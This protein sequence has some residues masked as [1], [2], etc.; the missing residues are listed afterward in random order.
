MTRPVASTPST[1]DDVAD[2]AK[3]IVDKLDEA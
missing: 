1:I 2:K 3:D